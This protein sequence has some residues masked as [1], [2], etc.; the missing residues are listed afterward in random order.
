MFLGIS[1]LCT[2]ATFSKLFC[3]ELFQTVVNLLATLLPI[4][5]PVA[6]AVFGITVFAVVLRTSV[7]VYFALSR[8]CWLYLSLRFLLIF[9]PIF[10]HIC[11]AKDKNP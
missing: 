10:S 2:S 9:L 11:L 8:S 1:L 6:S 7:S 3:C 4:K 5:S